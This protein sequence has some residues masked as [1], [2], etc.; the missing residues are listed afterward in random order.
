[1]VRPRAGAGE[2]LEGVTGS[3]QTNDL[4]PGLVVQLLEGDLADDLVAEVTTGEGGRR[5]PDDGNGKSET[6][7]KKQLRVPQSS[8]SSR[9]LVVLGCNDFSPSRSRRSIA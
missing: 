7:V 4:S 3:Y 2:G 1:M 6:Q 8:T 9:A 5:G